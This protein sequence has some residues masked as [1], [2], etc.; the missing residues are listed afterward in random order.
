M[1]HPTQQAGARNTDGPP[2]PKP[3]PDVSQCACVG[4][5][6][7]PYWNLAITAC[8]GGCVPLSFPSS[9]CLFCCCFLLA[10]ALHDIAGDLEETREDEVRNASKNEIVLGSSRTGTST[11]RHIESNATAKARQFLFVW[12]LCP[13]EEKA[14]STLQS[15]QGGPPP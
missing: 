12:L 10:K 11:G 7:C 6:D 2:L 4:F 9:P 13:L 15:S 3:C 5:Q 14:D 1:W 8:S